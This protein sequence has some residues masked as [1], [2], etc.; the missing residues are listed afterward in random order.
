MAHEQKD[1]SLWRVLG[2]YI[3]ASWVCLQVVDVLNQNIGLPSWVFTL[4]LG[5][6]IA[7]IPVI[8]ATAYFQGAGRRK[9]L[10]TAANAGPFTWKNLRKVA[11]AGLAVWGIIISG[12]LFLADRG[13]AD[14]ERNL[15]AG[16]NEIQRLTG[17]YSFGEAYAIA[18]KLDSQ[19]TDDSVRD[20]MWSEV[21]RQ[22]TLE[23]DPPGATVLRRDYDSTDADWTELGVTP[24]DVKRFP[25]GLSRLRFEL[26][27]YLTRETANFSSSIAEAGVFVLDTPE[28]IPPGMIRVSGAEARIWVPGLEQLDALELGDFFMDIHEVTNRQYKTFV[29]AGGYAEPSC[30]THPFVR[31][32]QAL[33][34]DAA[35]AVLV[36]QTGRAGPSGWQ[37]GSYPEGDDN[38]PVGGVSWYEA[39]AYACFVGK[40]LPSVYHWFTAA[41]PFSSNHVV[42]QSNYAG[43]GPAPVGQY[44]GLTRDGIYDMAGNMREWAQN[45]DGEARYILG[46]GWNDPEYAFNDAITSPAFDRSGENGIRLASYPDEKNVAA[47]GGPVVKAFRDYAAEQAVSDEVFDVYRQ[48]YHYDKTPIN[49]ITIE[50]IEEAAY[51]RER[52]ELDAAYGGER[53]T[54]FV[55]LPS[56]GKHSPPYQ[57]VVFFPGSNDIYKTS[58]DELQ[59]GSVDFILRSGRAIIYPVY[60]GTYERRSD[61]RSDIQD[62]SNLYR[63]HVIAWSRDVGRTIDYL[64]TRDDIDT[65]RLAYLGFSWGGAMGPI[66]TAMEPRFK[67][68]VFFVGGLMM[69]DVQPMA[70]P[71]NFLPR[72]SIPTFMFNGRYDSFFPVDTSIQPFYDNLGTP[73]ADRKLVITDSNHFVAAYSAN[74]LISETLDWLDKYLGVVE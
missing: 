74:R 1:R 2:I 23:T 48:M 66:M 7:G 6:L 37:V 68:S 46:G 63:D 12:W 59:L 47:A 24:L 57:S 55:F 20:S 35:M 26:D 60:K 5:M 38:L 49:A 39:A 67:T 73:A 13:S 58:Y 31:D 16:L 70:D 56:G 52:I 45:P 72:V 22:L 30:W 29:D 17:E 9:G 25:L 34:F 21:A 51:T 42:P 28:S 18:E 69:Q 62:S 44:S 33:S 10:G 50:S 19:I 40:S 65:K 53:L 4:T 27:G 15:I 14:S 64:E 71:F 54:I 43:A 11:V 3:A 32:G 61:L 36:D 8:A 41:D